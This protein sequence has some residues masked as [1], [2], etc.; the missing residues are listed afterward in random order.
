MAT[1]TPEAKPQQLGASLSDFTLQDINGVSRAVSDELSGKSSAV[2]VVW[3]E[4]RLRPGFSAACQEKRRLKSVVAGLSVEA[5]LLSPTRGM[6][7]FASRGETYPR[8]SRTGSFIRR[9]LSMT[10]RMADTFGQPSRC[11]DGSGYSVPLRPTPHMDFTASLLLKSSS[12]C[13]RNRLSL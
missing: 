4:Y 8:Y 9:Q 5:E 2:V 1:V 13:S 12:G 6:D 11:R 7:R 3:R 10:D